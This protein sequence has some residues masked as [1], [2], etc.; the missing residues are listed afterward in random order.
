MKTGTLRAI[1]VLLLLASAVPPSGYATSGGFE[2]EFHLIRGRSVP[3]YYRGNHLVV[4]HRAA[5]Y[6]KTS[7]Q[8]FPPKKL[9]ALR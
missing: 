7:R 4:K 2:N 9:K 3:S 6:P 1:S 8:V 5:K